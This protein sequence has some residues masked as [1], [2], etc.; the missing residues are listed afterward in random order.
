MKKFKWLLSAIIIL[1]AAAFTYAF[2]PA[3]QSGMV[4]AKHVNKTYRFIGTDPSQQSDPNYYEEAA[5]ADCLGGDY[6]CLISAPEGSGGHP[7]SVAPQ[8]I[9]VLGTKDL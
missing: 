8:D 7:S 2:T 6:N 9:T 4:S 3:K 1:A 5:E